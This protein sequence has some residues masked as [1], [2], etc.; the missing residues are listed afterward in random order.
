[1]FPTSCQSDCAFHEQ[2]HR[3]KVQE[4]NFQ[5]R[6]LDYSGGYDNEN[7]KYED[8]QLYEGVSGITYVKSNQ[9]YLQWQKD[10]YIFEFIGNQT[11]EEFKVLA[12]SVKPMED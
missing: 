4:Y 5:Q 6:T 9:T 7:L 2:P 3:V 1:M 8:V 11:L 12:A 10:G